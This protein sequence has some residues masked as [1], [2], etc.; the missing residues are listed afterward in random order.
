MLHARQEATGCALAAGDGASTGP[1]APPTRQQV[2]AAAHSNPVSSMQA[3]SSP[4]RGRHACL[5]RL[6]PSQAALLVIFACLHVNRTT[7]ADAS[8]LCRIQRCRTN[9]TAAPHVQS[10]PAPLPYPK[11]CLS[12]GRLPRP[13]A[14]WKVSPSGSWPPSSELSSSEG[15]SAGGRAGRRAGGH[16]EGQQ[17]GAV[18]GSRWEQVEGSASPPV[19][20]SNLE[21]RLVCGWTGT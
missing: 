18:R 4:A 5:C 6:P 16:S 7:H 9:R 17:V 8:A 21:G 14:R 12:Q 1:T 11:L 19:E 3:L 2:L 10:L 13:P 20:L 15:S